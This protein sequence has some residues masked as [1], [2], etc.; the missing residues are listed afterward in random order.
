MAV[1]RVSGNLHLPPT[2]KSLQLIYRPMPLQPADVN[3]SSF[4]IRNTLIRRAKVGNKNEKR[5]KQRD[6]FFHL[7]IIDNNSINPLYF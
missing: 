7:A 3:F 1:Y 6:H 5:K 4:Y 2:E